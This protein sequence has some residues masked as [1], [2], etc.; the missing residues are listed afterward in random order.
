MYKVLIIEE[1]KEI[2][3]RL[4]KIIDWE[5]HGFQIMG[6]V[7]NGIVGRAIMERQKPDIILL[8]MS[9]MYLGGR[10]F[11][12][13]VENISYPFSIIQFYTKQ[14]T[15]VNSDYSINTRIVLS[16]MALSPRD[17]VTTLE[18]ASADLTRGTE[19]GFNL[20]VHQTLS[21]QR[22][23]AI[24]KILKGVVQGKYIKLAKQFQFNLEDD[25]LGVIIL[26]PLG[27][28]FFDEKL[29]KQLSNIVKAVLSH[30]DGGEVFITENNR[31]G[32]VVKFQKLKEKYT[33]Y[34]FFSFIAE[35]ICDAI[36]NQMGIDVDCV[37]SDDAC[38]VLHVSKVYNAAQELEPYRYFKSATSVLTRK[39]VTSNATNVT[40]G[41]STAACI[42]YMMQC[43]TLII[44]D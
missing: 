16:R 19:D 34:L 17:L 43:A 7:S 14:S 21:A 30:H 32:A 6:V 37:M 2:S 42:N 28:R 23:N 11:I 25:Q 24:L 39:Y 4:I 31:L 8:S 41:K 9:A 40:F 5:E 22:N 26:Y 12:E 18:A 10:G 20:A 15:L 38:D 27:N 36:K 1:S 29:L 35:K 33:Q 44:R 13:A 3:D